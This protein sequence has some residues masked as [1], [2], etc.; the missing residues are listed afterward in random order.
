MPDTFD[1]WRRRIC[2]PCPPCHDHR[3]DRNDR[4]EDHRDLSLML[5]SPALPPLTDNLTDLPAK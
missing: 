4:R 2:P 1:P 5:P 3:D